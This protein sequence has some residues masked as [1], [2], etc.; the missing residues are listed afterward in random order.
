MFGETRLPH[1]LRLALFFLRVVFGLSF[2]YLGWT[3][4]FSHALVAQLHQHSLS[5][6][7]LWLS[8]GSG[9]PIASI[10]AS[11][12]AWI[13]L[14]VGILLIL[15]LFTRIA[16]LIAIILI[17]ANWLPFVSFSTGFNPAQIVNDNLIFCFALIVL[18]LGHA[19]TYL[20]LDKFIRWS[21]KHKE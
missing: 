3:T 6:L 20:G 9:T 2:F 11:V 13:F 7:Y 5:G 14:V 15:G 18:I 8:G 10:P 1:S 21:R 4:L 19:G 17:L 12:F 16:A